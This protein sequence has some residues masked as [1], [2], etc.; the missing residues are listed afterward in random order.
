MELPASRQEDDVES[1]RPRSH[2]VLVF[3]GPVRFE[4]PP[5][6]PGYTM[7]PR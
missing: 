3:A 7:E 6:R 1:A 5:L 4:A 2:A